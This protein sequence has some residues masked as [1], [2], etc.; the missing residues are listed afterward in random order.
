M[1]NESYYN[2]ETGK[3]YDAE[4]ERKRMARKR[5]RRRALIRRILVTV[6]LIAIAGCMV[7]GFFLLRDRFSDYTGSYIRNVDITSGVS[8][9]IAVWLS[10]IEG[11]E[12]DGRWVKERIEPYSVTEILTLS[13][14]DS[15]GGTYTRE[16]DET[17]Y[18]LLVQKVG[19][20]I[21]NMLSEIIAERLVAGGYA[22]KVTNEEALRITGEVL[23]M[24][25]S[26]YLLSNNALAAPSKEDVYGMVM[27]SSGPVTGTYDLSGNSITI[28]ADGKS[29]T[30]T[31]IKKNDV[32][33]FTESDR[34]YHEK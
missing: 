30:E 25:A 7:A 2:P 34:V 14:D 9:E 4:R 32:L 10:D 15:H 23:G 31:L 17:G 12:I 3:S 16:I 33:I 27:D 26:D 19:N 11:T 8:S 20:D 6:I 24:K 28:F 22:D 29:V 1:R 21:D 5:R 13:P 18:S